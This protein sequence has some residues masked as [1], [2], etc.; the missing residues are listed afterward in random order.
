MTVGLDLPASIP[1]ANL[2]ELNSAFTVRPASG[3]L[4]VVLRVEDGPSAAEPE[5]LVLDFDFSQLDDLR[6]D[7]LADYLDVAHEQTKRVF[8]GLISERYLPVMRGETQ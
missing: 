8:T 5:R 3:S 4:K 6:L 7:G 1:E 2:T